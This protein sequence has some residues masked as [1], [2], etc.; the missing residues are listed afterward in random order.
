MDATVTLAPDL[1]TLPH[2][3]PSRAPSRARKTDEG[4][5]TL[6]PAA[7]ALVLAL[8]LTLVLALVL[9]VQAWGLPALTLAALGLVPVMFALFAWICWPFPSQR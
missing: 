2:R 8:I 1:P 7:P 4:A 3:A 9:A 6:I 5:R